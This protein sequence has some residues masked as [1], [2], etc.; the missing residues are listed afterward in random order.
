M[1]YDEFPRELRKQILTPT[2]R[3][4]KFIQRTA[5]PFLIILLTLLQ[6]L[7]EDLRVLIKLQELKHLRNDFRVSGIVV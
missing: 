1:L 6:T 2:L 7:N 4:R 3:I 5:G